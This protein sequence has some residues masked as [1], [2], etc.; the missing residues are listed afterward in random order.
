MGKTANCQAMPSGHLV[1]D[2]ASCPLNWRLFLSEG[3]G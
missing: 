1:T 3:L 2:A